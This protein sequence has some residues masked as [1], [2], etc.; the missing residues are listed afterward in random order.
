[1]AVINDR[2]YQQIVHCTN[3]GNILAEQENYSFA[4]IEFEKA[5]ALVPKPKEKWAAASWI[6]TAIGD[7][8]F[9]MGHFAEAE[10]Q[11]QQALIAA[12]GHEKAFNYMRLGQCLYELDQMEGAKQALARAYLLEQR[13]I[14]NGEDP[15]YF[16]F[17]Q[18]YMEGI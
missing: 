17:L 13:E 18:Q 16:L 2:L 7:C 5:L 15:K 1:M 4:L 14:F 6:L 11:F 10:T 9:L 12:D 3:R 8:H